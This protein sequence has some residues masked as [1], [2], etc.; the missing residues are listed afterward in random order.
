MS[1]AMGDED[2][3]S[4]SSVSSHQSS[5]S[6]LASSINNENKRRSSILP[7]TFGGN[8]TTST[9]Q[10]S[11]YQQQHVKTPRW[12][13]VVMCMF[14]AF[15][16][17]RAV[18]YRTTSFEV[19]SA[20]DAEVKGFEFQK[21]QSTKL[22][23]DAT[24]TRNSFAKQQWKLKKTQ[25]LFQHETRMLEEMAEMELSELYDNVEIPKEALEKFKNRQ[26]ED[27][28]KKWIGHRQEAILHKIYNLQ[29]YIQ[30]DSRK[31]VI[32]KYGHGPHH[33]EFEV[34]SRE[35]RKPG[36]FTVRMAPLSMVPHAVETFLDMVTSKI[37]DNTIL[38]SHHTQTHVIGAAPVAYGT[39][40]SKDHELE[41]LGFIGVSFPE[42]SKD[43]PHKK[44]SVGFSGTGPN[45]YIN[46]MDNEDHHGPGG[47]QHHE[48]EGD[49]D[50]CFG[51]IIQGQGVM[52]DMQFGRHKG[53]APRGWQDYDL[54][55]VTSVKL[56]PWP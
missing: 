23:R 9:G 54:T 12:V 7:S 8:T 29:A 38:Y 33:V 40:K 26:S 37:W 27:I 18:Q 49:A 4:L 24:D 30:E 44:Y 43:F 11:S 5:F 16:W 55:R 41:T 13:L 50:P 3:C 35:G 6:S 22:L 15:S 1:C 25:R 36:K 31:R 56:V 53:E 2:D 48:L 14:T 52:V 34:K 21:Q 45:F 51:E 32:E 19:L 46:S 10:N 28:A 47:Q 39:F 17:I 20:M 42:Y